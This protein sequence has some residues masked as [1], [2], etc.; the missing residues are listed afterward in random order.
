[1]EIPYAGT[2]GISLLVNGELTI[3]RF[4]FLIFICCRFH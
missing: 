4:L 2:A 3:E 1:M